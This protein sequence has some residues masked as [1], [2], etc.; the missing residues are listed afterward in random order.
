MNAYISMSQAC[1]C[2]SEFS[3]L[4]L[5]I[6]DFP[7]PALSS[8]CKLLITFPA[9]QPFRARANASSGHAVWP[10]MRTGENTSAHAK[11]LHFLPIAFSDV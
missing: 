5:R 4:K 7:A 3:N 8:H 2:G 1:L 10:A 11:T 9:W 6:S